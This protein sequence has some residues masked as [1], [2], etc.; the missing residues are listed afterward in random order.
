VRA[1][2]E[3]TCYAALCWEKA[4]PAREGEKGFSATC[5]LMRLKAPEGGRPGSITLPRSLPTMLLF[6]DDLQVP[7]ETD[8]AVSGKPSPSSAIG[9]KRPRPRRC[10]KRCCGAIRTTLWRLIL[11]ES[12]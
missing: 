12:L 10:S 8:G 6:D 7:A 5:S 3:M 9:E 1:F 2:S 11:Q 4:W